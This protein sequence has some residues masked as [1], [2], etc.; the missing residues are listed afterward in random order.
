MR[1]AGR[2]RLLPMLAAIGQ[3]ALI[4]VAL[5]LAALPM[6]LITV[7]IVTKRPLSVS[8]GFIGGWMLGL[9]L[10]GAVVIVVVDMA[11]PD[12]PSPRWVGFAKCALGVLLLALAVR[13]WSARPRDGSAPDIPKW[14][15]AV[16]SV[17]ARK[18]V[19]LAFLLA[20]ANPKNVLFVVSAATVIVDSTS[21]VPEQAVALAVFVVVASLGVAAP[22]IV[23]LVLGD[24]S[25]LVLAA[26]DR[27][28]TRNSAVI[29]AAVLALLGVLLL[30]NGVAAL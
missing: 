8:V 17:T 25:G 6:V 1:G 26:A 11:P 12:G 15:S 9:A 2:A 30:A 23:H 19:G 5:V 22:A 14:M 18:A 16:E 7:V 24:R 20:A 13:K 3:S 29:M 21:R 10:V 27:W 28:M 4:A